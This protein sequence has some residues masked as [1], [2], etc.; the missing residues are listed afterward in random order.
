[1]RIKIKLF[2]CYMA[3]KSEPNEPVLDGEIECDI[4]DGL[5][6]EYEELMDRFKPWQGRLRGW[7]RR[8]NRLR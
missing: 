7:H 6:A 5:W 8:K 2:L 1:V 4:G 3:R